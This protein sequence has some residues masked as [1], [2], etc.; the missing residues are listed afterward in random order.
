M[1]FVDPR[2]AGTASKDDP[3]F[4]KREEIKPDGYGRT[5][6]QKLRENHKLDSYTRDLSRAPIREVV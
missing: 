2:F 4:I 3:R 6:S 5:K 1:T